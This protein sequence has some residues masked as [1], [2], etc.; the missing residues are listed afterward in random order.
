[1][2]F[3][4]N[5]LYEATYSKRGEHRRAFLEQADRFKFAEESVAELRKMCP[6][7]L[8]SGLVRVDIMQ[9]N[10]GQMIVNEFESLEADHPYGDRTSNAYYNLSNKMKMY[11]VNMLCSFAN[12]VLSKRKI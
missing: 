8:V 4:G 1:M 3:N 2:C 10:E 12:E 6:E 7:S 5:A 9:N 11:Y